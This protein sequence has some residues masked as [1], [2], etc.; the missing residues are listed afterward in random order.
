MGQQGDQR[1]ENL[2]AATRDSRVLKYLGNAP[3]T[4]RGFLCLY[5]KVGRNT[6]KQCVQEGDAN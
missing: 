3:T 6:S 1:S 4:V 5:V 2:A